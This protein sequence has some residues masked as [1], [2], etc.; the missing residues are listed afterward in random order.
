M[1]ARA[2]A[3]TGRGRT[4]RR[5]IT[6]AVVGVALAIVAPIA[7]LILLVAAVVTNIVGV[8]SGGMQTGGTVVYANEGSTFVDTNPLRNAWGGY[9]NGQ[10]LAASLC[11]IATATGQQATC[12]A[13]A[14]F[15]NLNAAYRQTFGRD[16]TVTDS[17]RSYADQ[18]A[19]KV[20]KGN[21]AAT[22]GYSNHGW[23][24]AFDLGGGIDDYDSEQYAW[25]KANGSR[26]A[27]FHPTWAEPESPD[28]T[29]AEPWH[30]QFVPAA[31]QLGPP[32]N[33]A[34][35]P[36]SNRAFGRTLADQ[37]KGWTGD[38]WA[39]LEQLWTAESGWNHYADNPTSSAYGIPQALP[40]SK[41]AT[42]GTDWETNPRTQIIWGLDY[43]ADRY[44]TP[45]EAW[46]FWNRHSPHWY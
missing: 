31:A 8:D 43:I 38:E 27:F 15:A 45:C 19:I 42:A 17:Y 25:M 10:I 13:V 14:A 21:L 36:D 34:G 12:D 16:I 39:C 32:T 40:G 7:G 46:A 22:P 29:K 1:A 4:G 3:R 28:F 41:M 23:G 35:T 33:S 11:P 30:W 2:G 6:A 18:V 9:Q 5:V 26:F 24:L 20:A 37:N 44:G